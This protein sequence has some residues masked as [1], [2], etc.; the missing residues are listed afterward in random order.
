MNH[1]Q[2]RISDKKIW[3]NS[4]VYGNPHVKFEDTEL[5]TLFSSGILMSPTTM[6]SDNTLE[7][8]FE[9]RLFVIGL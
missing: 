3:S 5:K 4:L 8:S 9:Q 7:Q 2:E 1:P 6:D